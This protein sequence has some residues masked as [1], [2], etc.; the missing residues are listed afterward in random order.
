MNSKENCRKYERIIT[1]TYPD[2]PVPQVMSVQIA[3]L[4][5]T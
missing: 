5:D 3:F 2:H 4:N 1:L